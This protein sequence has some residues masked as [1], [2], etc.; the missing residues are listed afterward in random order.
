MDN[1]NSTMPSIVF[2]SKGIL[3]S[4]PSTYAQAIIQLPEVTELPNTPDTIRGI[5]RHRDEIYNLIDFRKAI[6]Y[7]SIQDEMD[8]F[9]AMIDQREIDHIK[10]LDELE[11]SIVENRPF[12]LTTDPHKCAFGKWYDNYSSENYF[13]V[14]VL[15]DFDQPHRTIHGIAQKIEQLKANNDFDGAQELIKDTRHKELSRMKELFTKI[16]EAVKVSLTERVILFNRNEN[17]FAIAVDQIEAVE[18]L[19]KIDTKDI[20]EEF[21][22]FE[23]KNFITGLGE[24][25]NKNLIITVAEEYLV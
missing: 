17:K 25:K 3:F 8:E 14:D 1:I 21:L 23:G 20:G 13:I 19:K 4:V 22:T 7:R 15:K 16:K 6:A 12:E 2:K 9:S 5:I 11:A 24:D 18:D 10:W